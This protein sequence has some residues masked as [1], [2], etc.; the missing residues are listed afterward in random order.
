M[1]AIRLAI[2]FLIRLIQKYASTSTLPETTAQHK[3]S[4]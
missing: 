4:C 2:A 1:P 3:D